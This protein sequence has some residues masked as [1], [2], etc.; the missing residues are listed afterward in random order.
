MLSSQDAFLSF[1]NRQ[2]LG[3]NLGCSLNLEIDG[4]KTAEMKR[5]LPFAIIAGVLI[6]ALAGGI[7][8]WPSSNQSPTQ[9]FTD[10]SPAA[11]AP[12]RAASPQSGTPT[13]T[14]IPSAVPAGPDNAHARGHANAKVVLEEYGDYQCPPCGVLFP[15]LNTIEKEYGS[16]LR[17]VF[18]HFPLAMHKHAFVAA[19]AAEAAARQGRFWE[20]H[21]MIY[22]NQANWSLAPDARPVFI[23]Y[24]RTLQLDVDRFTRDMDSPE[25]AASVQA[26]VE[27]GKSVGVE[28]TPTLFINGRQLRPEIVTLDGLR[29][30]LDFV[31]GKKK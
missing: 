21:D 25:V 26:D 6:A 24:A 27:R 5:Y 4:K 12:S 9:P 19:H 22:R 14:P 16:Q 2:R 20:M 13:N 7:A 10:S 29:T 30:A 8:L 11:P 3:I 18:R 23:Q 1:I 15:E 17:F 31:L 28:G